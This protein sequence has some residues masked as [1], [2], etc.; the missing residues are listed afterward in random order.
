M[1][2]TKVNP[3]RHD[4]ERQCWMCRRRARRAAMWRLDGWDQ[5][6]YLCVTCV[7]VM[8]EHHRQAGEPE[9]AAVLTLHPQDRA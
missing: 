3:T 8:R 7:D 4:D 9:G 2:A 1:L 5:L 6:H